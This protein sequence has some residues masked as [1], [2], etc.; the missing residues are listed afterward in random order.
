MS[1]YGYG[2]FSFIVFLIL[3]LLIFGNGFYGGY[4]VEK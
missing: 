1:G 2:N 4:S 3:I